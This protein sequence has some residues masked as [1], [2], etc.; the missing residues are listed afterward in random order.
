MKLMLKAI[1][2]PNG[3]LILCGD[4]RALLYRTLADVRAHLDGA[5]DRAAVLRT[6]DALHQVL[7]PHDAPLPSATDLLGDPERERIAMNLLKG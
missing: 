6:L 4:A 3:D 1:N 7:G 2:Q 5:G